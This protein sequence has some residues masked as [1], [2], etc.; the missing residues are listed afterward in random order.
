MRWALGLLSASAF[1]LGATLVRFKA[2]L[3][4]ILEV[5]LD[6]PSKVGVWRLLRICLVATQPSPTQTHSGGVGAEEARP[7]L[8]ILILLMAAK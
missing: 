7:F 2:R 6:A 8:R 5:T 4:R 3:Q 1:H